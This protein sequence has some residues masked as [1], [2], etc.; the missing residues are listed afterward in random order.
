MPLRLPA[1]TLNQWTFLVFLLISLPLI[2][3]L[4]YTINEV[5]QY[6]QSAQNSLLKAVRFTENNRSILERLISME[7]NIRQYQIFQDPEILIN[8]E[9][10]RQ[11][12]IHA[13]ESQRQQIS[14]SMLDAEIISLL[15]A[16][17]ILNQLILES[18]SNLQK[19][20]DKDLNR[21]DT[22]TAK[23]ESLLLE[24]EKNVANKV[25]LLSLQSEEFSK[26]LLIASV[27]SIFVAILIAIKFVIFLNRP[28]KKI[29]LEIQKLADIE[30]NDTINIKGP[31]DLQDIGTKL[32]WLRNRLMQLEQEKQIFIRNISHELKTPLA[33][34]KE[35]TN[36]LS[37]NIVGELNKEQLNIVQLIT[38]ANLNSQELIDNLLEYQKNMASK[39]EYHF[40]SFD[41]KAL[42]QS[43]IKDYQLVL[44]S[45]QIQIEL[46]AEPLQIVADYDKIKMVVS[47]LLSNA[48]KFSP[49]HA[50]IAITLN[51]NKTHINL[52]ISDQGSGV[53]ENLKP[54]IFN[55]FIHGK[56]P[57]GN[58]KI[59]ASGIGLALVKHYLI[60]H[61]GTINLESS[62]ENFPGAI[63]S[64]CLPLSPQDKY[65]I[66][67]TDSPEHL[68]NDEL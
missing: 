45:Q 7:R 22:L 58:W 20:D 62:T 26:K 37:E 6:S 3:A 39:V 32:D 57:P 10:N 68:S 49:E 12:F 31:K 50:R 63:F 59:K 53:A 60:G 5:S 13:T 66:S 42:I 27:F 2:G 48:I 30:F 16:E 21:F 35:A 46:E 41:I 33:T 47:N 18:H 15:N 65:A 11:H 28:I 55:D 14:N 24:G 36:L 4:G 40:S 17:A 34:I 64:I 38:L 52:K 44:M 29:G 54:Y 19:L 67:F 9:N 51:Q 56:P 8:Y 25:S 1:S 43:V 61:H 23:A